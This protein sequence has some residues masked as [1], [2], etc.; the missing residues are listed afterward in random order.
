MSA[1]GDY[2]LIYTTAEDQWLRIKNWLVCG[3][4]VGRVVDID[5]AVRVSQRNP[6]L[7]RDDLS[8]RHSLAV[9]LQHSVGSM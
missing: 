7:L 5:G 8:V 2:E 3:Y 1:F 4:L 6:L 9:L